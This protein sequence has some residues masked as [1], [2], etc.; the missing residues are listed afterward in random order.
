[1]RRYRGHEVSGERLPPALRDPRLREGRAV[2]WPVTVPTEARGD[3]P[4]RLEVWLQEDGTWKYRVVAQPDA[5]H[6]LLI[7]FGD[8]LDGHAMRAVYWRWRAVW[9]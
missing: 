5:E 9:R 2:V 4:G 6:A 7:A 3:L 8:G 1:M